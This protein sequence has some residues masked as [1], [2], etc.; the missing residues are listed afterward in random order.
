ME[1]KYP[2]QN[3]SLKDMKGE[4]WEDIPDFIDS[5]QVSNYGRIK[6]LERWVERAVKGDL[7][8]KEKILKHSINRHFNPYTKKYNKQLVLSLCR[9]AMKKTIVTG[10]MVY[11]CFVKKFNLNDPTLAVVNKNGDSLNI[12]YSNLKLVLKSEV[13]IKTYREQRKK[14]LFKSI[15]QYDNLGHLIATYS[16]LIQAAEKTGYSVTAI[17]QVANGHGI[18]CGGY[19]WK[20]GKRKKAKAIK[21]PYRHVKRIA[22]YTP[23]GKLV[24]SFFSISE[25]ERITG[26]DD[27]GIRN[28]A[29]KRRA[30]YKGFVWKY[31]D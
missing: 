18:H 10:R 11:Y 19:L 4:L 8:L 22:Q 12:H 25:A 15:S 31:I 1:K 9:D 30:Q 17:S 2:Y 16:S 14:K 20:F 26:F 24:H 13:Q 28:T 27:M 23:E 5:Y 29:K 3:L 21:F 6:A 7:H